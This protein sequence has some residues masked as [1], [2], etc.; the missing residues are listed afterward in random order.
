M[1]QLGIEDSV[2]AALP[3]V[4]SATPATAGPAN[5]T[6]TTTKAP[7]PAPS[8][9]QQQTVDAIFNG[10]SSWFATNAKKTLVKNTNAAN[11][12]Q[13]QTNYFVAGKEPFGM[14]GWTTTSA[15]WTT[16]RWNSLYQQFGAKGGYESVGYRYD[17]LPTAFANQVV[18]TLTGLA[19]L[20]QYNSVGI[21]IS[22]VPN[23]SQTYY[24][25]EFVI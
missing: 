5:P 11:L 2:Y 17:A 14:N 8:S 16:P 24:V 22:T 4:P 9:L 23:S 10:L 6:T 1:G 15:M 18:T 19:N 25:V 12:C 13:L 21:G 3:I 20:A 7:T